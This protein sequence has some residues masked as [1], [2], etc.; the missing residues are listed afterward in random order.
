MSADFCDTN[1]L[2]YAYDASAAVR[3]DH[4]RALIERLWEQESGCLSV[5]VLQELFVTLT[6]KI[7][8]P[9]QVSAARSVVNDL[10][11]WQV[12]TP[13]AGLVLE[14][15]D[16]A[17]RWQLSFWDSMIVTCALRADAQTLW[18]EDLNDGQRFETVTVRNPF[19]EAR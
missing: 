15:I 9:L 18:T 7:A 6:R 2:V 4:A 13:N 19:A 12:V 10:S 1:V 14:A 11:A 16:N 17:A 5:Q 3:H 8:S